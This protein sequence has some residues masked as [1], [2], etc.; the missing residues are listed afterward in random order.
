MAKNLPEMQETWVQFLGWEDPLEQEMASH[1][2]IS[3]WRIPWTEEPGG[4]QCMGCKESDTTEQLSTHIHTKQ[5]RHRMTQ[6]ERERTDC[7]PG[8]ESPGSPTGL[9]NHCLQRQV[10][11]LWQLQRRAGRTRLGGSAWPQQGPGKRTRGSLG[12]SV[13]S[14]L[15]R[16]APL[17]R[18]QQQEEGG[19]PCPPRA[20]LPSAQ[21]AARGPAIWP[22]SQDGRD[23]ALS[24]GPGRLGR[25]GGHTAQSLV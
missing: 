3:A 16:L 22:G 7:D 21:Q 9:P 17:A 4:L 14:L 6:K 5:R 25:K 15:E 8:G 20:P 13:R 18:C 12:E 24:C 19:G 1:S 2:N 10:A 11:R 23:E